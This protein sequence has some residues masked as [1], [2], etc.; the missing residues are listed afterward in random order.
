MNIIREP[1]RI[2]YLGSII[3]WHEEILNLIHHECPQFPASIE[4]GYNA[5]G[6]KPTFYSIHLAEVNKVKCKIFAFTA[7]ETG[8]EENIYTEMFIL[9]FPVLSIESQLVL[10]RIIGDHIVDSLLRVATESV[11]GE[12]FDQAVVSMKLFALRRG[13][14][15][16]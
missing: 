9:D 14:L 6:F 13:L 8:E 10:D 3:F 5:I 4:E 12:T 16:G 11:L 1:V 15:K 7:V 2:L